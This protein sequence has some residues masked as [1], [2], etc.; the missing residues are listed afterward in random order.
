MA[1]VVLREASSSVPT[2]HVVANNFVTP[3]PEDLIPFAEDTVLILIT[4]IHT[5]KIQ[6]YIKFLKNLTKH[7]IL[8]WCDLNMNLDFCN[9]PT[10]GTSFTGDCSQNLF[11]ESF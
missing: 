10:S 8:N 9:S 4:I 3:V 6:I 1:P 7:V 2:T 5:N 11:Y